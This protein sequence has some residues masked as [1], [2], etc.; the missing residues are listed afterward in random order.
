MHI[1]NLSENS[2]LKQCEHK[3]TQYTQIDSVH[4]N[5]FGTHKRTQCTPRNSVQ[6]NKLSPHKQNQP[7]HCTTEESEEKE[8]V[9]AVGWS[10]LIGPAAVATKRVGRLAVVESAA[11][12]IS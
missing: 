8:E 4:A 5:K 6:T 3:Q 7:T 2:K 10:P 9:K 12:A 1:N 11:V